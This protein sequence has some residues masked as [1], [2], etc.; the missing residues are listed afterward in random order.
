MIL[1]V[2]AEVDAE[3]RREGRSA[4]ETVCGRP[5]DVRVKARR[6]LFGSACAAVRDV[7]GATRPSNAS[8]RRARRPG[9]LRGVVGAADFRLSPREAAEIETF[10]AKVA[11]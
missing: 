4:R 8:R 10:F 9:Q 3:R 11:A 7:R 2:Y 1:Y 5:R 6:A